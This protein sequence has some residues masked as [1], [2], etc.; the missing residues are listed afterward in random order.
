MRPAGWGPGHERIFGGLLAPDVIT[1][2]RAPGGKPDGAPLAALRWHVS[3]AVVDGRTVRIQGRTSLC[4]DGANWRL[5]ETRLLNV[6]RKKKVVAEQPVA[7]QEQGV[8]FPA[9]LAPARAPMVE[10]R[11]A[12]G[13]SPRA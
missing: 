11:R 4:S 9:N 6:E 2:D 5:G 12:A 7:E 3:D 13:G 10:R 8:E 1:V